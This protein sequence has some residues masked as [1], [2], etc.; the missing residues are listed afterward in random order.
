MG[1]KSEK[2]AEKQEN[3]RY[4]DFA[5]WSDFDDWR[6]MAVSVVR[7]RHLTADTI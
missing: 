7:S 5:A 6:A 1:H 3:E 2:D 4:S